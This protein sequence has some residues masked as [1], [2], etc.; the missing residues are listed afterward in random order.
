MYSYKYSEKLKSILEK[1]YKKETLTYER[2][3][4]KVEEVINSDPEH[5]KNLRF[6]LQHLKRVQIGEKVIAIGNPLG[7]S[8]SVTE[9]IIS[10]TDREGPNGKPYYFQTDAALNPGNSGGPLIDTSG[11]IIGINNFKASGAENIG[12]ALEIN[13][14]IDTIND[15]AFNNLNH[16]II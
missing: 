4:K 1:L 16:T 14:A 12:F 8:F 15:I 6:P 2:V 7:L 3:L 11:E 10:A 13:H 9:G 5:Y